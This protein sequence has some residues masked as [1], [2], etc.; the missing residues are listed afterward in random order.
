[1][2]CMVNEL[3]L[4]YAGIQSKSNGKTV[5]QPGLKYDPA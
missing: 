5:A 4:F 3:A 1:M 2:Y